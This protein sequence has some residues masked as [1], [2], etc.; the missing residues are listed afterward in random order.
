MNTSHEHSTVG[1][2][3]Y[4]SFNKKVSYISCLFF[5]QDL[6]IAHSRKMVEHLFSDAGNSG[7]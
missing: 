7:M 5:L 3:E 6:E 2:D 1:C 4:S